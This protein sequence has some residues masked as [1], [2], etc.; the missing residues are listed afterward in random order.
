MP[1]TIDNVYKPYGTRSYHYGALPITIDSTRIAPYVQYALLKK[2]ES[3]L[4][5]GETGAQLPTAWTV[6]T[7]GPIFSVSFVVTSE[8]VTNVTPS[9]FASMLKP[10]F[11]AAPVPGGV[12]VTKTWDL[13]WDSDD[14]EFSAWPTD[15]PD[16]SKIID[17]DKDTQ[18]CI[19][20]MPLEASLLNTIQSGVVHFSL[21]P[22]E[23]DTYDGVEIGILAVTYSLRLNGA[24][25]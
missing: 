6:D 15:V 23:A 24:V 11:S 14:P 10:T 18:Y 20:T 25:T 7:T 17:L 13:D 22:V 12:G 21:E 5:P 9:L 2:G 1:E 19:T 8:S 4:Q 16:A 3:I